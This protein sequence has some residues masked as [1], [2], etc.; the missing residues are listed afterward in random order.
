MLAGLISLVELEIE[1]MEEL[2]PSQEKGG[3]T[4]SSQGIHFCSG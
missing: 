3:N 4:L 1:E 2:E